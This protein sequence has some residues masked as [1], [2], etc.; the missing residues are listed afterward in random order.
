MIACFSCGVGEIVDVTGPG[1]THPY[2]GCTVK[3][4]DD[5]VIRTCNVCES[6]WMN[7]FEIKAWSDIAEDQ[8]KAWLSRCFP[9]SRR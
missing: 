8:R 4:P 3:I 9:Y 6:S 2:R 7:S 1:R 5:F